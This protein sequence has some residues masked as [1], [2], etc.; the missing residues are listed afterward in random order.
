MHNIISKKK[1]KGKIILGHNTK[2]PRES[3][4]A[5]TPHM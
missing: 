1:K 4:Q 3:P 5:F 2:C